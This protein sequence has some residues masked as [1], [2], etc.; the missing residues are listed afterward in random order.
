MLSNSASARLAAAALMTVILN[1]TSAAGA[2]AQT[3]TGVGEAPAGAAVPSGPQPTVQ[4]ARD[5]R[6]RQGDE[7]TVTVFGEPTLTPPGP[8]QVVQGGTISL[9]LVGNVRVSGLTTVGASSAIQNKLHKYLHDPRVTLAI[10]AVG[11]IEALVLGNVKTPGKFTLPPPARLTDVL[12]A[13]GGLGPTD[14]DLPEAR[15]ETY[16]GAVTRISLQKLLHD[17][18][19]SLNVPIESGETVYIQAPN[20][21]SVR[22]IGAVDKPGDVALHDGDDLAMAI[23][24]AGTSAS[25]NAD[26]N[27]ITVTRIGPD[28]KAEPQTIDLYAVLKRGDL[29][30]DLK[31][32]K[33][34]LVYV[35]TSKKN[36]TSGIGDA[37]LF[38]RSLLL[39]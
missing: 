34:D 9:P 15:L 10:Y 11:P 27:H 29:T 37:L 14:G 7:V 32:Q 24:R 13:A 16:D 2:W 3:L 22:V 31:M 21:F 39:I 33:N 6:I 28:G 8:L 23:A 4:T 30:H 38:L 17:G 36:A 20:T 19:T 1:V 12:A 18:D 26:L 35:P 25:Q 5:Y